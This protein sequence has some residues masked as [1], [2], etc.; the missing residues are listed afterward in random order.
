MYEDILKD[1]ENIKNSKFSPSMHIVNLVVELES[2]V[3]KALGLES[4]SSGILAKKDEAAT[5]QKKKQGTNSAN[6]ETE[7]TETAKANGGVYIP[8]GGIKPITEK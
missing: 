5:A 8:N 2:K 7:F 1:F 3:K 6:P 4:L